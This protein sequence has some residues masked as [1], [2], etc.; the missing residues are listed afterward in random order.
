MVSVSEH[1]LQLL[2]IRY[3]NLRVEDAGDIVLVSF[4]LSNTGRYD[5]DEVA[6][7]YMRMP[8]YSCAIVPL[9]ELKGFR[10]VGVARLEKE[11]ARSDS[12][13]RIVVALLG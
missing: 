3:D 9:K 4:D 6:Q 8:E 12:G 10:R 11:E 5:G 1:G 13:A 2:D 7:I